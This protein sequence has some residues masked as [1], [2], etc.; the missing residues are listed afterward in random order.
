LRARCRATAT[1]AGNARSKA[2]A[3]GVDLAQIH[4]RTVILFEVHDGKVTRLAVYC[5]RDRAL[6]DLALEA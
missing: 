6:A 5:D 3:N 2:K 4:N 1:D